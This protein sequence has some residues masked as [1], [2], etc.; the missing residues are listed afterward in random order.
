MNIKIDRKTISERIRRM[1][2][3]QPSLFIVVSLVGI[4][5]SSCAPASTPTTTLVSPTDTLVQLTDT[6]AAVDTPIPAT[7]TPEPEPTEVPPTDTAVVPTATLAPFELSSTAFDAN[8]TIPVRHACHG[9][10]LSPELIWTQPP[11]GTQSFALIMDDP[12]AVG[13]VGYV[14]D[15]WLFFN[16][17]ANVFSLPEGIPQD[18]EL[19]DGSRQGQN[20][21]NRIGYGGPCPPSGQTHGYVF[22]VYALDIMLELESG[23]SKDQILEASNG[24]VLAEA[25]LVGMYTS[26]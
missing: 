25:Q 1:K 12:D 9:D 18:A 14:W 13:V 22:T 8:Q 23:V 5:L 24:H 21:G 15:H 3:I 19:P 11:A 16:I 7:E 6:Q 26:P 10:N 20:S 4:V 17:P 2:K